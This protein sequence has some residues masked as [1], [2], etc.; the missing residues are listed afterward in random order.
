[1]TPQEEEPMLDPDTPSLY[2]RLGGHDV[3]SAFG[4]VYEV[5][6]VL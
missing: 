2:R 3:V 1:M 4:G 6:E 5:F